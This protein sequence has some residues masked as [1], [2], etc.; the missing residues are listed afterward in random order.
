MTMKVNAQARSAA[1]TA[2][3]T[4]A[5][6]RVE[7]LGLISFYHRNPVINAAVN[8]Y[9]RIKDFLHGRSRPK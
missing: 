4:R 2:V 9:I 1:I 5:D 6:G 8:A 3:I 7:R